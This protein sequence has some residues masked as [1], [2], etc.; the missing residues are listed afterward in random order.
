M[1]KMEIP[2]WS[3]LGIF[4]AMDPDSIL[5]TKGSQIPQ[6]AWCSQKKAGRGVKKWSIFLCFLPQFKLVFPTR[7]KMRKHSINSLGQLDT[8]SHT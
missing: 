3:R 8:L 2:W 6:A 7:E 1:V 4:A 5:G